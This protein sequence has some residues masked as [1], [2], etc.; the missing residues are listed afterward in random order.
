LDNFTAGVRE[1]EDANR[2]REAGHPD[3]I[4]GAV[5]NTLKLSRHGA[6][7]LANTFG[8]GFIDWLGA[9]VTTAEKLGAI[10]YSAQILNSRLLDVPLSTTLNDMTAVIDVAADHLVEDALR[11]ELNGNLQCSHSSRF[12]TPL[13]KRPQGGIIQNFLSSAFQHQR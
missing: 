9:E 2:S 12:E 3:E 1:R 13:P 5:A 4:Q 11:R 6:C 10:I 8:V 7:L